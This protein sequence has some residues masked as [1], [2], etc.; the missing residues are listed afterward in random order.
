MAKP[1]SESTLPDGTRVFC[2]RSYEVGIIHDEMPGYF[3]HGVTV[4]DGDIVFDVGA[5]IG[6][7]GLWVRQFGKRITVY[8]F[9]PIPRTFR[10]LAA[11]AER[12]G[13]GRWNV[14]QC[15][16]GKTSGSTTFGFHPHATVWSS[17]YPDD[18]PEERKLLRD[19]VLR[20]LASCHR[21]IRWLRWLP[22]ILRRGLVNL[23][24]ARAFRF[25]TVQCPMRTLSDVVREY[26]VPRIDLLKIDVQ[27]GE[28][29]VLEGI[30]DGDWRKIRQVVIEIHDLQDDRVARASALLR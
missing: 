26:S 22:P 19:A 28:M 29:D 8:S 30:A 7:F 27:R 2:V 3:R 16:L 9:E 14:F 24:L 20:N 10:A 1:L 6:L 4:R 18:S 5:N 12:H 23:A 13:A 11:N 25:K 15:G 17:A 21:S